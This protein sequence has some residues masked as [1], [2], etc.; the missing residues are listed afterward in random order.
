MRKG[1]VFPSAD[2]SLQGALVSCLSTA[3]EVYVDGRERERERVRK[4][5]R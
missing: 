2:S 3:G 5:E 4:K 1:G